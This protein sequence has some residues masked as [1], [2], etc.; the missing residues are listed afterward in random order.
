MNVYTNLKYF[1]LLLIIASVIYF[2]VLKDW[3]KSK[4]G[5]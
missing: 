3:I 2:H 5:V 1:P 4:E